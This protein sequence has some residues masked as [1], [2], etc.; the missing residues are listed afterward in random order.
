MRKVLEF[1][2]RRYWIG[3]V[4]I[5]LLNQQILT[6]EKDGWKVISINPSSDFFG[7]VSSYTLLI[8]ST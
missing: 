1:K 8:E 4:N 7:R 5:D 6:I 3:D 2:K